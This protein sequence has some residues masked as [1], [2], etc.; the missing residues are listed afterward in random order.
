M[1]LTAVYVQD[2]ILCEGSSVEPGC[3][4]SSCI[5]GKQYKVPASSSLSNQILLD[6]DRMMHV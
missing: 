5:V 4:L 3:E 2:S 6:A 1:V